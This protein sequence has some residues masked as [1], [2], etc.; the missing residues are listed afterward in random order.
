M[1]VVGNSLSEL[2][3]DTFL[4]YFNSI[5]LSLLRFWNG[6]KEQPL[7]GHTH[8]IHILADEGLRLG[9]RYALRVPRSCNTLA[10]VKFNQ[11]WRDFANQ[12]EAHFLHELM[13]NGSDRFPCAYVAGPST[14]SPIGKAYMLLEYVEGRHMIWGDKHPKPGPKRDGVLREVANGVMDMLKVQQMSSAS[15]RSLF[16][17]SSADENG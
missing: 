14:D 5:C 15:S 3:L 7:K 12:R 8:D 9:S 10:D 1:R 17:V 11:E 6:T 4:D 16:V 13:T 2:E